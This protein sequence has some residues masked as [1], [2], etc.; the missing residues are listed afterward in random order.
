MLNHI[1]Q[2]IQIQSE[3]SHVLLYCYLTS[4]GKSDFFAN[5]TKLFTFLIFETSVSDI[6]MFQKL[7]VTCK[8]RRY[9]KLHTPAPLNAFMQMVLGCLHQ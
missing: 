9:S 3:A 1:H 6:I 8:K 4:P 2:R 5:S 7:K